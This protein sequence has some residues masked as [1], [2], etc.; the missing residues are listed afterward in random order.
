[1]GI[2][3]SGENS[4]QIVKFREGELAL[5][6]WVIKSPASGTVFSWMIEIAGLGHGVF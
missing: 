5:K 2:R 3:N 4:V 1:M 6:E